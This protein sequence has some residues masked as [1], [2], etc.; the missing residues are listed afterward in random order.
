MA[1]YTVELREILLDEHSNELLNNALS[2]YP[3]YEKKSKEQYI[4][5]IVPTREELNRKIIDYYKYREIGFETVGRFIDELGIAMCEI[6]P[7]YN[8][9]LY[10]LDQD[11]NILYNADYTRKFESVKT[12]HNTS[13]ATGENTSTVTGNDKVTNI[14]EGS[15]DTA[16]TG[17]DNTST[18]ATVT[19]S[20][21][22]VHTD[23][24][25]NTVTTPASAIDSVSHA[26]DVTWDKNTNNDSA[27]STGSNSGTSKTENESTSTTTGENS[28]TNTGE[29]SLSTIGDNTET[30]DNMETVRGNYGMV[31]YQRLVAQYRELI[32][33]VEQRIIN[34][35]RI[36]EL[37]MRIY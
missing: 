34:D 29:N 31:S 17:Q 33:N 23:T 35:E 28:V 3:L 18:N 37:F 12:G 2:K 19:T 11:Y 5:S 6:M 21:K 24:P 13:N 22:H 1:K 27:T 26:T 7:K 36:S 9:I 14:S 10:T 25:Q 8:Q 20:S 15:S 30:E 16:T 4:P 32:V